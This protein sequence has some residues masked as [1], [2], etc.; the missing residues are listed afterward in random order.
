MALNAG[1][2]AFD[3]STLLDENDLFLGIFAPCG[4]PDWMTV[5]ENG[6]PVDGI[7]FGAEDDLLWDCPVYGVPIAAGGE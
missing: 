6:I 1:V 4:V 7:V 5:D 3:T 2:T